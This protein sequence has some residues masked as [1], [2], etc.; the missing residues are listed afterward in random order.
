[1][2]LIRHTQ[3]SYTLTIGLIIYA[4]ERAQLRLA[5]IATIQTIL[6]SAGSMQIDT[7]RQLYLDITVITKT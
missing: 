4:C 1:M 6:R 2:P 5:G 7:L 3:T